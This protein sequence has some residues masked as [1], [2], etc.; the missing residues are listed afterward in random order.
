MLRNGLL[1]AAAALLLLLLLLL[2]DGDDGDGDDH[3]M[4]GAAPVPIS[5]GGGPP[6]QTKVGPYLMERGGGYPPN[7]PWFFGF[8]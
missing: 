8:T 2:E 6:T 1:P 3:G 4:T 7:D 5:V